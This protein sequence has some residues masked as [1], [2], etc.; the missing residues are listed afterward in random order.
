MGLKT[1]SFTKEEAI[2]LLSSVTNFHNWLSNNVE[3]H[4]RSALGIK[5]QELED[6]FINLE[7]LRS[8]FSNPP[9]NVES[10]LLP[11]LKKVIIYSRRQEA[12][13]VEDR[14][15]RTFNHELKV[16]LE[17]KLRLFSS[18]I[19]QD[20]FKKT[21]VFNCPKIT[22]FLSIQHA[23]LILRVNVGPHQRKRIYD[24]KF[25]IL[26]APSEFIPDLKYYRDACELRGLPLCVAYVD[27]DDFKEFNTE[28]GEPRVDRDIL[29]RFM[30]ALEAHIYS[31]GH[32]YRYGGDEYVIL[33][34]NINSLQAAQFLKS[35]QDRLKNLKF[36]E[37]KKFIAVSIGIFE[38]SENCIQT[39]R[40]VEERAASAKKCSKNSGK[41][42]I[43]TYQKECFEDEDLYVIR[44]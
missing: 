23:E 40:E 36:F 21:E 15:G 5:P 6:T 42:C 2:V 12:F 28:Y 39:D 38:V 17:E 11:L 25:N 18:I 43:A 30:T 19:D 8:N 9:S 24:E 1:Q 20:W 34:P 37:I 27:I 35:F 26:N 7:Q 3:R 32:A 31:H 44:T 10:N 29:P 22:D 41:N 16:R 14:S 13:N 4:V 33:L